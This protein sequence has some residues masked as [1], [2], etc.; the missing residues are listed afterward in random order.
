MDVQSEMVVLLKAVGDN[1][2]FRQLVCAFPNGIRSSQTELSLAKR[3]GNAG[4]QEA[5]KK[6]KQVEL[7]SENATSTISNFS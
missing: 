6:R 2:L 1:V 5:N 4:A 7:G 3:E